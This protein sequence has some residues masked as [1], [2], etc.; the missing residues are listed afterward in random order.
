MVSFI[1][2]LIHLCDS[3]SFVFGLRRFGFDKGITSK[4][5]PLDGFKVFSLKIEWCYEFGMI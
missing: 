2:P 1:H 4:T 3:K 5:R